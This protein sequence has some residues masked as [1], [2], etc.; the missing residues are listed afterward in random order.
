MIAGTAPSTNETNTAHEQPEELSCAVEHARQKQRTE[1]PG[2]F[3][4][5]L[6]NG[7]IHGQP[8]VEE[9]A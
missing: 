9:Y 2:G 3:G 1:P 5:K 7:T 8:G 6:L 4:I